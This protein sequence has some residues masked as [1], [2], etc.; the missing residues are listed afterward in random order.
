MPLIFFQACSAQ[1]A[2]KC[3]AND[4]ACAT[5]TG[6]TT[7]LGCSVPVGGYWLDEGIATACSPQAT[8]CATDDTD[9]CTT[10]ADVTKYM[11]GTLEPGYKADADGM[12]SGARAR[13]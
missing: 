1:D 3:S 9:V 10:G 2:S 4:S 12:V 7:T 11:C 13:V 8:G 6:Q 5:K